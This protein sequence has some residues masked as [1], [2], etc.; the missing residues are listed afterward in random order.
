MNIFYHFSISYNKQILLALAAT[1]LVIEGDLLSLLKCWRFY[2]LASMLAFR[3]MFKTES[4]ILT[5]IM[6]NFLNGIIHLKVSCMHLSIIIFRDIKMKT[7]SWSANSIEPGQI[8]RMCVPS[9]CISLPVSPTPLICYFPCLHSSYMSLSMCSTPLMCHFPCVP[10]LLCVTSHVFHSSYVSLPMC[11]TPLICHFPCVPLLLHVTSHVSHSFYLS[12]SMCSTPLMYHFPYVPLLLC[13][14]PYVPSSYMSLPMSSTLFCHFP[15]VPFSYMSLPMSFTP[16]IC[17]FPCVPLLLFVTSHVFHSS[18]L[19]FSMCSTP[20]MYHFPYVPLLLCHLPYVPSSY[21]SLP[22][23]STLFCHFP[24]VPLSYMSLHMSSTPLICHFP[25]VPLL[26]CVTFHVSYS[27]NVPF[28][29]CSTPL[30]FHLY[31]VLHYI[32]LLFVEC[33]TAFTYYSLWYIVI[34]VHCV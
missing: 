6:P 10:L 24:C 25:C 26:L 9:F 28:P 30:T 15:C 12:L 22:M 34:H 1:L 19:S 31:S 8:A 16:L 21:M 29:V 23:S 20:L 2:F 5:I 4:C 18:Y 14:L 3:L 11:S 32:T 33:C 17:H 7:W 13:H 27:S